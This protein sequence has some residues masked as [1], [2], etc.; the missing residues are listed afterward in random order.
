M[1]DFDSG[2]TLTNTGQALLF[3]GGNGG[4]S[5]NAL[6]SVTGT[7]AF[8]QVGFAVAGADVNGDAYSDVLIG[9][10]NRARAFHG[11]SSGLQASAAWEADRVWSGNFGFGHAVSGVGD[12]NADGYGDVL[13]GA[14]LE[15]TFLS[16]PGYAYVYHGHEDFVTVTRVITYD[17]DPLY[18][19][20]EAD[21]STSE[22]FSYTYDAVGNRLTQMVGSSVT[23]YS[24]DAATPLKMVV[25]CRLIECRYFR[26][27]R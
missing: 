7:T 3:T 25:L 20:T 11:G 10:H 24:F 17:Y 6:W 27:T 12:V 4:L 22:F 16:A 14:P 1:P 15:Y 13:V 21:Y 23:T 9:A 26:S 8:E 2:A 19:L 18:R 5:S